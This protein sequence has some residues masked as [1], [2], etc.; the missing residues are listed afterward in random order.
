MCV[1]LWCFARDGMVYVCVVEGVF[2]LILM[3]LCGLWWD[4]ASAKVC[5]LEG[6]LSSMW[7]GC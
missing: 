7:C 4:S 2:L 3:M 6:V 1:S 5:C